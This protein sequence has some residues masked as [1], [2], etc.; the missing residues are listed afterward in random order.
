MPSRAV[1]LFAALALAACSGDSGDTDIRIVNR[2][3]VANLQVSLTAPSGNKTVTVPQAGVSTPNDIQFS[4][5]AAVGDNFTF[6][7]TA[8]ALTSAAKVCTVASA[9][10]DP[11]ST[12]TSTTGFGEVNVDLIS[13]VLSVSCGV[14][15]QNA[16]P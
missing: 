4:F 6:T 11:S 14:N 12:A 10:I 5:G 16:T 13:G 8:G 1:V 3:N 9:M 2:S 15:W 7:A